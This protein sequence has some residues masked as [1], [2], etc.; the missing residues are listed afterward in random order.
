VKLT[1]EQFKLALKN[2]LRYFPKPM[3]GALAPEFANELREYGH[4]YMYRLRP[5]YPMKA[6]P[7]DEYPSR[8]KQA[9]AIQLMIMN[10]L[11][12]AV[13]Q[14]PHELITY[15]G[16]GSVFSNWAQYNLTMQY[17]AEMTDRQTLVMY[18]GHPMGLFPSHPDA[19]RM[20]ISNGIEST[21]GIF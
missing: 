6:Y 20:I 4:I 5:T 15:G 17:L 7:L 12:N 11:D 18:S 1:K 16:N 2:A 9:A 10:N 3:H 19:P 14:F 8:C 21:T 13:A